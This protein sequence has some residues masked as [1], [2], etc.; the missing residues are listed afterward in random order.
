MDWPLLCVLHAVPTLAMAGLIWFVQVVHY[1]LFAAVGEQQFPAY[2]RQH[3]RR[4]GWVVMPLMLAELAFT[5]WLWWAA[6]AGAAAAARLGLL[7]LGVVWGSTFLLQVPGHER[8]AR[9]FDAAAARRLVASNWLRTA[10]W[11][12]RAAVA[13][14][15]LA[16]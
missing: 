1:P 3:C 9:G 4:T 13:I 12:A 2:E 16:P 10:A 11:S 7:L 6:P 14:W 8:L 15:L 5:V